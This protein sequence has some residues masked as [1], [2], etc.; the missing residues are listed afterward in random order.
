MKL[1]NILKIIL[2]IVIIVGIVLYAKPEEILKAFEH[3][4][5]LW[6]VP[7]LVALAFNI[8]INFLDF[9]IIVF[10]LINKKIKLKETALSYIKTMCCSLIIPGQFGHLTI[11]YFL[12]K[13]VK[14]AKDGVQVFLINKLWSWFWMTVLAA[15]ALAFIFKLKGIWIINV[16]FFIILMATFFVQPLV[17]RIPIIKIF[18]EYLKHNVLMFCNMFLSAMK[19]ISKAAWFYFILM[20]CGLN[21]P[22]YVIILIHG[23]EGFTSMI[24]LS[25]AGFGTRELGGLAL[26]S[27]LGYAAAPIV[28]AY[29]INFIATYLLYGILTPFVFDKKDLPN[30]K[31]WRMK[32][33]KKYFV[34]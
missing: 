28:A 7:A 30:I 25:L 14:S 34:R 5:P 27:I 6:L 10:Y 29:F 3:I 22:Y 26:Y 8:I 12:R 18:S 32:D 2:G 33:V 11:L 19:W 31:K 15:N 9:H 4:N 16:V 24:P 20:A 23:C 13:Y 21:V 1:K 17:K